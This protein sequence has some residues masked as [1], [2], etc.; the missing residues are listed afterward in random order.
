MLKEHFGIA[1]VC[2]YLLGNTSNHI[3]FIYL[4]IIV[5][6]VFFIV[7]LCTYLE[8]FNIFK[9]F[10]FFLEKQVRQ[11]Y[12][13]YNKSLVLWALNVHV[14]Q[15]RSVRFWIWIEY[16]TEESIRMLNLSH[17]CFN[18]YVQQ[19]T[20]LLGSIDTLVTDVGIDRWTDSRTITVMK[21]VNGLKLVY[22]MYIPLIVLQ[23]EIEKWILCIRFTNYW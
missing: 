8:L 13:H 4:W 21:N 15:W 1:K 3:P 14:K 7:H 10:F 9:N 23:A 16:D 6:K 5:L 2:R 18:T 19:K 11:L 17:I 22:N 20:F 12:N